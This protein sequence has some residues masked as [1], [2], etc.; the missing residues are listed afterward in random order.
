[1]PGKVPTSVDLFRIIERFFML[2]KIIRTSRVIKGL[3][4]KSQIHHT[5]LK[6]E[7][8]HPIQRVSQPDIR[9]QSKKKNRKELRAERFF[10]Q[11][12]LKDGN[13]NIKPKTVKPASVIA[14]VLIPDHQTKLDLTNPDHFLPIDKIVPSGFDPKHVKAVI[15]FGFLRPS[16]EN[17]VLNGFYIPYGGVVAS[18]S[19]KGYD[20]DVIKQV[21]D[22]LE[23]LYLIDCRHYYGGEK[24]ISLRTKPHPKMSPAA[25]E[26]AKIIGKAAHELRM[27]RS[28]H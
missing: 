3:S 15:F 23:R 24:M 18:I 7:A 1:M 17:P 14:P 11:T 12:K 6:E 27:A 13:A 21:L 19:G 10:R 8:R 22:C 16:R 4:Y 2:F 25:S 9:E 28:G 20:I 26:I 5:T